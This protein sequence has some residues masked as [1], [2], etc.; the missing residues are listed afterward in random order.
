[1]SSASALSCQGAAAGMGAQALRDAKP[2]LTFFLPGPSASRL[3]RGQEAGAG[4]R[5]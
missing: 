5:Q 1:M 3:L 4:D 2:I